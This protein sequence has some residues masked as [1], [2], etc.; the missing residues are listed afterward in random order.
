MLISWRYKSDSVYAMR[1]KV[2]QSYSWENI[3]KSKIAP[4]L[5]EFRTGE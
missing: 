2:R 1:K 4:L 5:D 3:Y